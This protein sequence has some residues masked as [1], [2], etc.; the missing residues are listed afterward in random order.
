MTNIQLED[1]DLICVETLPEE[2]N[3]NSKRQ[4]EEADRREEPVEKKTRGGWNKVYHCHRYNALQQF[5]MLLSLSY[6][7]PLFPTIHA[8]TGC[9]FKLQSTLMHLNSMFHHFTSMAMEQALTGF[10]Q[11]YDGRTCDLIAFDNRTPANPTYS[12]QY[13]TIGTN[14]S[15]IALLPRWLDCFARLQQ[16]FRIRHRK[17]TITLLENALQQLGVCNDIAS[18]TASCF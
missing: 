7:D 13:T 2:S 12:P 15:N 16:R 6:D 9:R 14:M 5:G 1:D 10:V 17:K 11:A 8:M 18:V 3:N 4:L